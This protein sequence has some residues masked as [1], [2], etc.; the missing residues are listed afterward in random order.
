VSARFSR[1]GGSLGRVAGDRSNAAL[2]A[3]FSLLASGE[4]AVPRVAMTN[5]DRPASGTLHLTF[6]TARKTEVITQVRTHVSSSAATGLTLARIGIFSV[7][8]NGDITLIA[9]TP[10]DVTLWAATNTPYTKALSASW[11]KQA[12]VRYA[13]GI[14]GIGTQMPI[15]ECIPIRFQ[16]A[17]FAPRLQGEVA[18]SDLPASKTDA[19]LSN[20]Y[21]LFQC[22]FL[23]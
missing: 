2:A 7:A 5:E 1:G 22:Y 9:S 20:Q 10:N 21:R 6:F 23:P 17:G 12:G 11:T 8:A 16:S 3:G 18:A 13:S 14:L 19:Q 15:L 4:E